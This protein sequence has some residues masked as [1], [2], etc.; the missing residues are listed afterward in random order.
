MM[1]LEDANDTISSISVVNHNIL[2]GCT[3]SFTRLYDTR[4]G[5]MSDFC[6]NEAVTSVLI[7]KDMTCHLVSVADETV[8]LIDEKSGALLAFFKGH[9]EP[10]YKY[11]KIEVLPTTIYLVFI[12]FLVFF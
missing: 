7:S 2:V 4:Q 3:D 9:T 6:M 1:C 11:R 5:T 8:K 10:Q 12:I